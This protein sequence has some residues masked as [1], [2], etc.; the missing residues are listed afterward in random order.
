MSMSTLDK[1]RRLKERR[2]QAGGNGRIRGIFHGWK[3][4]DN[5]IR[6]AGSFLEV[7]THFIA[8]APKRQD[9]GLCRADAFQGDNNIPQVV[10]CLD[11][12]IEKEEPRSVKRCPICKLYEIARS[13]LKD[14]PT[15][16]EKKFFDALRQSAVA[17]TNLK[18]NIIDRDDPYVV[19][20]DNGTEKRVL[21]FKVATVGMEA[22]KDIEGIFEQ[23]NIDISDPVKGID[24]KVTKG[25][26]GTRVVYSAQA[27]LAGERLKITPFSAEEA[28]MPLHDLKVLCGK[29]IDPQRIVDSLHEDLMELYSVNSDDADPALVQEEVAATAA[30]VA[31]DAAAAE[32]FDDGGLAA[33]AVTAEDGDG[34]MDGTAPATAPAPAPA[35]QAK[36]AAPVA[37]AAKPTAPVA[38]KPPVAAAKPVTTAPI[39]KVVTAQKKT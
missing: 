36:P 30:V 33:A 29:Q 37:P 15:P 26:N 38:A 9:R 18:W 14:N 11:W 23:C 7:R 27:V 31:D 32:S 21:G 20:T 6:L 16:E 17:R 25:S 2:P 35:V 24:I 28:A 8:P 10:N 13:V 19:L 34:L 12:D 22:W 4:G 3:D 1:V 39:R 5:T